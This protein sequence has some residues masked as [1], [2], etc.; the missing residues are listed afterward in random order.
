MRKLSVFESV[1]LNGYFS[2]ADGDMSWAYAHSADPEFQEFVQGNASAPGVLLF[3]RVTYQMMESYWPT[4][5]ASK[6]DPVVA[7]G[8]NEA[9]KVVFS[10]TL[11]KVDWANTRLVNRRPSGRGQ[12]AEAAI[13]EGPGGARQRQHRGAVGRRRPGGRVP[14]RREAGGPRQGPNPLRGHRWANG[15]RADQ[16]ACLWQRQRCLD[17][18]SGEMKGGDRMQD[19]H[20]REAVIEGAR[21]AHGSGSGKPRA[22][23][24]VTVPGF[25]T[26]L[27]AHRGIL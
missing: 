2:G 21:E 9:E 6:N 13:R 26:R 15:A 4:P 20:D 8:M 5:L 18:R 17:L 7:K 3:G 14:D 25:G 27:P 10:R 24:R 23:A 11:E 12:N 22:P 1:T 16:F 19:I